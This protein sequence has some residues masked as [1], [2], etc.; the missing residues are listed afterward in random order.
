M[1]NKEHILTRQ[2]KK[3]NINAVIV[4]QNVH[5]KS[6]NLLLHQARY[7]QVNSQP[8]L[9]NL[10][11]NSALVLTLRERIL[12]HEHLQDER[13]EDAVSKTKKKRKRKHRHK[14]NTKFLD[15][16]LS[17]TTWVIIPTIIHYL[18]FSAQIKSIK[19][20]TNNEGPRAQLG[21]LKTLDTFGNFQRP[22]FDRKRKHF[23]KR[24]TQNSLTLF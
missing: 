13:N 21:S 20:I 11:L 19:S 14:E 1:I 17:I 23:T 10:L 8:Q 5:D 24:E 15:A 2:Q 7:L 18:K 22:V 16:F 3:V 9:I 4:H 6:M 12:H